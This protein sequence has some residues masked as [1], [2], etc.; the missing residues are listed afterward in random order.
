[1]NGDSHDAA[2]ALSNDEIVDKVL[3]LIFAASE[4]QQTG[5]L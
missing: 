1:M 4:Q 2:G 3:T 5:E